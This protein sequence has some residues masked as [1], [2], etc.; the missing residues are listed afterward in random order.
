VWGNGKCPLHSNQRRL[1]V[2]WPADPLSCLGLQGDG[3][4]LEHNP[5]LQKIAY[6]L[7]DI[8]FG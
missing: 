5:G 1:E 7:P 8:Q 6:Y 3:A 2:L 4:D